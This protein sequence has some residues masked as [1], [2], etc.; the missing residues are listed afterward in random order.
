MAKTLYIIAGCNGAG[1]STAAKTL[2][3]QIWQCREFVNADDIARGLSPYNPESVSVTAGKIMLNRIE[4]LLDGD[5]SFSVETTLSTR[6][7]VKVIEKAREKGFRVSLLFLWLVSPD[8]ARLRVNQRVSEGGHNIPD[9]VVQRRY[10]KGISNLFHL[11][12]GVC[13][14]WVI[15]DNSI[16]PRICVAQGARGALVEILDADRYARLRDLAENG[17][18][19]I[20]KE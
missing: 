6:S 3:P 5:E 18:A 4:V 16:N 20:A 9:D 12:L 8:M 10:Y 7:Y 15:Y 11:F 13:D 2:L 14:E 19:Q 17:L 1:K